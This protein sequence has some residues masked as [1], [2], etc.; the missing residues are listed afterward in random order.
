MSIVEFVNENPRTLYGIIRYVKN[1]SKT[2]PALIIGF[3]LDP[4]I[5]FEEMLFTK[6]AYHKEAGR[7][8]KQIVVSFAKS[9]TDKL[10]DHV[11]MNISQ[12]IA[13][14]Y[15]KKYQ[16]LMGVHF[17]KP[18]IHMHFII[19]SVSPYNNKKFASST[20][21]LYLFKKHVD[22]IL[23]RYHLSPVCMYRSPTD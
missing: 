22:A 5:A 16:I 3:G 11:L 12:E 23:I 17:N 4:S 1:D 14:Y 19:N 18:N 20:V 13:S 15:S 21:D 6:I 9:D 7:Q 2:K 8:Y 10:T